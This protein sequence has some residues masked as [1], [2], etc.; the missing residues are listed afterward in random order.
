MTDTVLEVENFSKYYDNNVIFQNINFKVA[1]GDVVCIIGSSGIGKS[2]FLRCLNFLEKP[3]SGFITFNQKKINTQIVAESQIRQLRHRMGFVFQD[4]ALFQNL[5]VLDNVAL[6]LTK[7][8]GMD[9]NSAEARAKSVLE[10]VGMSD[11]LNAYPKR[12]SGGQKQ[13]VGIA[14]AMV[15][16]SDI[17]LMDEPTSSLDRKWVDEILSLIKQL[18][19]NHQTMIIVT[20]ELSFAQDISSQVVFMSDGNFTEV[21]D[22]NTIFNNPQTSSLKSFLS[23][24]VISE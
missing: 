10:K 5:S 22:P 8:E 16:D 7:V 23:N 20:H 9:K 17:I 3:S 6:S 15:S 21:G 14:R 11:F 2:T 24:S 4:I 12:L 13:R 1:K 18:Q 19:E